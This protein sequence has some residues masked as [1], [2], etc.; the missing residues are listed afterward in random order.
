[1]QSQANS[2]P[3]K[4]SL[5]ALAQLALRETG[6][7][8]YALFRE[9]HGAHPL[10]REDAF[11]V[12]IAEATLVGAGVSRIVTYRLGTDGI[13][14][15]AY[16]D[17]TLARRARVQLDRMVASIQAVWSAA[18]SAGR[19]TEL[20]GIVADLEVRLMDSKIADRVQGLLGHRGATGAVDTIVR[21]VEGVLRP[22]PAGR[23]LEELSRTLEEEMEE[24]RVTNR[25]KAVLQDMHGM[26]EEEAHAHL[27]QASR[28]TRRKIKDIAADL[29]GQHLNQQ[30]C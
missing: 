24:R 11:G 19:Y 4:N 26:S 5:S 12:A 21:H 6:A 27:R 28:R 23:V 29:I 7:D 2:T 22:A 25:A 20:A 13:L 9:S 8:G 15:F 1:M 10:H 18:R 14:A 16:Y 17:E 3:F 30:A